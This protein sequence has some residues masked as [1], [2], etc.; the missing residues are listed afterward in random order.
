MF[1]G[2]SVLKLWEVKTTIFFLIKGDENISFPVLA[3][4]IFSN[5]PIFI[6]IPSKFCNYRISLMLEQV[7]VI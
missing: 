5:L 3:F 6:S 2:F 7:I 1:E 4:V